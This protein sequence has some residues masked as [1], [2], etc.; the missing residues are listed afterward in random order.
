MVDHAPA[1]YSWKMPLSPRE[2]L[3]IFIDPKKYIGDRF[4]ES[5]Y[6]SCENEDECID[7]LLSTTE[8]IFDSEANDEVKS[9]AQYFRMELQKAQRS[10][11]TME[12]YCT[13]LA[14]EIL[15]EQAVSTGD[16][17]RRSDYM[18]RSCQHTNKRD[19]AQEV[20]IKSASRFFEV[21]R[22]VQENVD[23]MLFKD[24]EHFDEH[25]QFLRQLAAG[26]G[27]PNINRDY[28]AFLRGWVEGE[29]VGWRKIKQQSDLQNKEVLS[30]LMP[31]YL[32]EQ[33][34][35]TISPAQPTAKPRGK[36]PTRARL[37]F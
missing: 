12:S 11:L 9:W 24:S 15:N 30:R 26:G 13:K 6:A 14:R 34:E 32:E 1:N 2:L 31:I 35:P 23:L 10:G 8:A 18:S 7:S 17:N 21:E 25:K 37:V 36:M 3:M 29:S 22:D 20:L 4:V 5:D 27:N 28:A 19:I 16:S 33:R